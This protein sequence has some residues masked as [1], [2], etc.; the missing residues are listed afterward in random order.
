MR[1]ANAYLHPIRLPLYPSQPFN[2]TT[3]S[4]STPDAG[5]LHCA[6]SAVQISVEDRRMQWSH[7]V[8][9]TGAGKCNV[10]CIPGECGASGPQTPFELTAVQCPNHNFGAVF[11]RYHNFGAVFYRYHNFGAF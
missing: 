11:Y 2:P 5:M 9:H 10:R 8:D 4:Q 7:A 6:H 3:S 1:P